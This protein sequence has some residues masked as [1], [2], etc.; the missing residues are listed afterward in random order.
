[1]QSEKPREVPPLVASLMSRG[2]PARPM[3]LLA[4]GVVLLA[5]STGAEDPL[6]HEE[7]R[8]IYEQVHEY[9]GLHLSELARSVELGTN[10]AKYHLRV[11]EDHEMVSSHREN[12]YV[13]FYP[14]EESRLG[15]KEVLERGEKEW[16][17][18]LRREVPLQMTVVLLEEDEAPAGE[19]SDALD[20][21]LSTVHYHATNMEEA[22]LISSYKDGRSRI[23]ELS[24]PGR[25]AELLQK[26]EP[27]DALVQGFLGAWE[28][29]DFP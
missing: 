4:R 5:R 28:R 29:L 17:S 22:G 11:L 14:R 27:P 21:A 9:P 15:K 23:Y 26:H 13:R 24:D 8:R 7:R 19:I 10:H 20:V 6:D 18:L 3:R 2:R 1:M 12:G 25:V 16:L